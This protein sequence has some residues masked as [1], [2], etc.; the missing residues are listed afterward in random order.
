MPDHPIPATPS[1]G[2]SAPQPIPPSWLLSAL[3]LVLAGVLVQLTP[4]NRDWMVGAHGLSLLPDAFWSAL[5]LL[6]FGWSALILVSIADRGAQGARAVLLAFLLGG[7]LAQVLKLWFA[8]PRPG[9]VLPEGVLHFIGSPVLNSPSMP[10]GHALAAF[11]V[12]SLWVCLLRQRGR[13]RRLELLAWMLAALMAGSRIAVGA[14]WP[15]DVLVGS[16]LGL[17]TGWLA[18]QLQARWLRRGFWISHW[19]PLLVELLAAFAAF[20]A[21]EGYPQV[22]ALQWLLGAVALA[23]A[24]RRLVGCWLQERGSAA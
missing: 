1:Q 6:A 12:G 20:S 5:T 21:R 19:V 16:G 9:L 23:S 11:S 13:H 18:W 15:A 4:L 17:A 8:L 24:G 2:G 3:A 10:S 22:L 7:G 14:H